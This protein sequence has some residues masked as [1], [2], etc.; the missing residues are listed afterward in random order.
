MS[1]KISKLL[2]V[3]FC[4]IDLSCTHAPVSCDTYVFHQ[5]P[6]F[7]PFRI[8]IQCPKKIETKASTERWKMV[9]RTFQVLH[10]DSNFD[11]EYD[12]D[13]GFEVRLFLQNLLSFSH[14]TLN[15]T[16]SFTVSGFSIP[17]LLSHFRST[18]S[19][20]GLHCTNTISS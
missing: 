7:F 3:W 5:I 17:A 4:I 8:S 9:A 12:T 16:S 19:S 20:K 18:R 6:F 15:F 1:R 13:D 2:K 11:L 10:N 14:R